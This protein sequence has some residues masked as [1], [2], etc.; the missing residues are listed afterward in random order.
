[1]SREHNWHALSGGHVSRSVGPDWSNKDNYVC[2][3]SDDN[4]ARLIASAPWM[5]ETLKEVEFMLTNDGA[6]GEWGRMLGEIRALLK[7]SG[8][9]AND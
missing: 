3:V 5:L 9:G 4:T 1:M 2:S 6:E 8:G 7:E